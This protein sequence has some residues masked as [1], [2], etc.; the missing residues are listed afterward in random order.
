ML[1]NDLTSEVELHDRVDIP[2]RAGA[3]HRVIGTQSSPAQMEA[4]FVTI[5]VLEREIGVLPPNANGPLSGDARNRAELTENDVVL[6]FGKKA[7][8]SDP[9]YETIVRT[10]KSQ[11]AYCQR[12]SDSETCPVV[13]SKS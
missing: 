3:G 13:P 9:E 1:E 12:L 6:Q 2:P 8:R 4:F 10:L 5:D 11:M 7:P